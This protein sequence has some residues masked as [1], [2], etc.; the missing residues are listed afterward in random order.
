MS[1]LDGVLSGPLPGGGLVAS[2]VGLVD[3][4]DLG[5]ERV[6]GV[7]VC[8]HGADGEEHCVYVSGL[9]VHDPSRWASWRSVA[10]ACGCTAALGRGVCVPFEMVSAGLHWSL[11]MS[12]QM[13]PLLLMLG[14]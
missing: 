7:G 13:E 5:D 11:K 12:K 9:G 4:C 1:T 10:Y 3:M 2:A 8:E 6:V 14:W